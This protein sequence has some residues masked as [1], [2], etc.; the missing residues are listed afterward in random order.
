MR[1]KMKA[2]KPYFDKSKLYDLSLEDAAS[3]LGCDVKK[4]RSFTKRIFNKLDCKIIKGEMK[5]SL[6]SLIKFINK[7]QDEVIY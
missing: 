6:Y 2:S 4:T 3:Y 5:F 7:N 1:R